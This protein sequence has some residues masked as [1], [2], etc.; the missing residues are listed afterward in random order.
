[1]R[2]L[3]VAILLII[4]NVDNAKAQKVAYVDTN[5]I[6]K[7]LPEYLAAQRQLDLISEQ[8]SKEIE[9]LYSEAEAMERDY[10]AEQMLMT[11]AMRKKREDEILQMEATAKELQRMKFGPNGELFMKQKQFVKPIQD[12]VYKAIED[13]AEEGMYAIIFDKSSGMLYSSARYDKSND[14]LKKLGIKAGDFAK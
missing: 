5:Y 8:W 7:H 4:F 11:D 10:Q 9:A 14:V 3:A 2:L 1:M 13:I 6:L 12:K